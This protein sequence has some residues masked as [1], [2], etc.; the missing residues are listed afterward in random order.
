MRC[1]L[2]IILSFITL[3]SSFGIEIL[4]QQKEIYSPSSENCALSESCTLKSFKLLKEDFLVWTQGEKNYG[5]RSAVVIETEKT[6]DLTE[7]VVVQ[8]IKGCLFASTEKDKKVMTSLPYSIQNQGVFV[9][10]NFSD[11]TLDSPDLDPA[12]MSPGPDYPELNRHA[13]YKTS[14]SQDYF[15]GDLSQYLVEKAPTKPQF[16]ITDR[17]GEVAF[18]SQFQPS[19]G[20]PPVLFAKNISLQFQTC[21][22]KAKAVATEIS[23]FQLTPNDAIHCFNW[24]S[25]FL[26]NFKSQKYESSSEI[27]PACT[28]PL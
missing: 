20:S 2:L 8:W 7:Y 14:P 27:S 17:P 12:S 16:F 1:S 6:Q 25:S 28:S 19:D 4:N 9:P 5:T 22:F 15:N 10:F 13:F 24:E 26:Y 18:S 23:H 21:L 3:H 11:W